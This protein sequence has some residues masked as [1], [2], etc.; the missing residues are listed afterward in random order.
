MADVMAARLSQNWP[1]IQVA[2]RDLGRE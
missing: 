1:G 2:H